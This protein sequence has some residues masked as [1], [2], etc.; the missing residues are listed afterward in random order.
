MQGTWI[1]TRKWYV[2]YA[3]L[4][5]VGGGVVSTKFGV[6]L[7]A[8]SLRSIIEYAWMFGSARGEMC[9]RVNTL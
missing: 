8:M 6:N 1:V 4:K 9:Y 7:L 3:L 2:Q 5:W